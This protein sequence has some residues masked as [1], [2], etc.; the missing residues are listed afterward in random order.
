MDIPRKCF[1]IPTNEQRCIWMDAGILPYQLCAQATHCDDCVIDAAMRLRKDSNREMADEFR[2]A[3][4][5]S[6]EPTALMEGVRYS[7]NHWW[8]RKTSPRLFRL[9]LEPGLVEVLLNLKG[10]VF[11]SLQPIC[12]GQ[13]CAWAVMDG[14]TILLESPVAGTLASVNHDLIAK[15]HLLVLRPFHDGWLCDMEIDN[16]DAAERGLMDGGEAVPRFASDQQRFAS[17]LAEAARGRRMSAASGVKDEPI[18]LRGSAD[19]LGA[20]RYLTLVRQCFGWTG[21]SHRFQ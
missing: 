17:A 13:A 16:L 11:P 4:V 8:V 19:R 1:I 9:G 18:S 20:A 3:S 5:P 14:G 21:F 10:I 2:T 7:R 15:P 6:V 12:K